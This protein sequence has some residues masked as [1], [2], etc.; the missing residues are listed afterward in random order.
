MDLGNQEE[1]NQYIAQAIADGKEI[2]IKFH[3][4]PE[5]GRSIMFACFYNETDD[6]IVEGS[7]VST[8]SSVPIFL[9]TKD[10]SKQLELGKTYMVKIKSY[11]L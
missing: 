5:E 1:I 8:S 2:Y 7:E 9:R 4:I 3:L 11:R 6:K 10:I